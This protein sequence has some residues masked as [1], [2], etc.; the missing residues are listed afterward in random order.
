MEG[1]ENNAEIIQNMPCPSPKYKYILLTTIYFETRGDSFS[2][3]FF[4]SGPDP[5]SQLLEMCTFFC[6]AVIVYAL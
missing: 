4:P 2:L 1:G 6:T 5:H 3:E